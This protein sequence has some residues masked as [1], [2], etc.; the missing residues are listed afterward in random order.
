MA[1]TKKSALFAW[2]SDFGPDPLVGGDPVYVRDS[3]G[4][5]FDGRV[6]RKSITGPSGLA[7]PRF[8]PVTLDGVRTQ[9]MLLESARTSLTT[10]PTDLTTANWTTRASIIRTRDRY[11]IEGEANTG[12][13]L[14]DDNGADFEEVTQDKPIANDSLSHTL[15]V[16]VEKDQDESRFP[17]FALNLTGGTSQYS[18]VQVNTKTGATVERAGLGTRSHTVTDAGRWWIVRISVANNTSGN[19]TARSY[20]RPAMGTAFGVVDNAAVGSIVVGGAFLEAGVFG[21]SPIIGAAGTV[22]SGDVFYWK[23][24]PKPQAMAAYC[25][26]QAGMRGNGDVSSPRIFQFGAVGN[27]RL[28]VYHLNTSDI[29]LYFGNGSAIANPSLLAQIHAE[30]DV[31][32]AA[33]LLADGSGRLAMRN[34]TDVAIRGINFAAPTGGLPTAWSG[35][36]VSLNSVYEGSNRG[37]SRYLGFHAVNLDDVDADPRGADDTA[38]MDELAEYDYLTAPEA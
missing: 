18:Y 12:T 28:I 3:A 10:D 19:T 34:N 25:R 11:G 27:P 33:T 15:T 24:A 5:W 14:E 36:Y 2:R 9:A 13:Y 16:V 22:R 4:W 37:V 7:A 1:L 30:E 32:V 21:T 29:A 20:V 17:E 38:L 35:D 6:W 26:F 31:E 8:E 23:N